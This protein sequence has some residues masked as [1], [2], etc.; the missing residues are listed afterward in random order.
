MNSNRTEYGFAALALAFV[1]GGLIGATLGLL[2]APRTG[3]E[4]REKIKDQAEGA[5]EKLKETA[6]TVRERA[7][8]LAEAGKEKLS[9]VREKVQESVEK[10]KEKVSSK[11]E[12]E[13]AKEGR[14]FTNKVGFRQ[15]YLLVKLPARDG[16]GLE[17]FGVGFTLRGNFLEVRTLLT[18][19]MV[20]A[21]EAGTSNVENFE[22][23]NVA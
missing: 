4:T 13:E 9:E 22:A 18:P 5:R 21:N 1:T 23:F 6:E 14:T 20:A 2:F 15:T 11:N 7:E 3:V 19:E 12:A 16:F 8:G 10:I 17:L